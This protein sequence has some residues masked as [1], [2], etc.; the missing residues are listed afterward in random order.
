MSIRVCLTGRVSLEVDGE[1]LLNESDLRGKQG[2]LVFA[3]LVSE[4]IRPV[5]K[6]ELATVVWED[7]LSPA[8]EGALSALTS[9]LRSHL[10]KTPLV[11]SGVYFARSS[12]QYQLGLPTDVWIDVEAVASSVDRAEAHIRNG[13]PE[14]VL[15]PAGAA[16]CIARRPFLPGIEGFWVDSVRGKLQRQLGRALDCLSESQLLLGEPMVAVETAT[17]AIRL[18]TLREKAYQ[19][20]MQANCAIGN[21]AEAVRVYHQ[22]RELLADQTGTDPS[23]QTEPIYMGL[24]G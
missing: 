24:L 12:G 11:E 16:V 20:L 17:E 14:Q 23:E 8:W 18:D 5:T 3:Y 7:D 15:G 21:R 2:R 4:R 1:V 19:L 9:R 22:F 6:E 13:K 10:L